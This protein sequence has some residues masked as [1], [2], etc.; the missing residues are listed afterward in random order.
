MG[1]INLNHGAPV[2]LVDLA[3][4]I[5]DRFGCV[6]RLQVG[7]IPSAATENHTQRFE[8]PPVLK[9]AHFRNSLE[10]VLEYLK[11]HMANA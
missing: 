3:A 4:H 8:R 6:D 10:S 1:A 2:R 7:A 5:F 11:L 9:E